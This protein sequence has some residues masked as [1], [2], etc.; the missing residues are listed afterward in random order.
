LPPIK[1]QRFGEMAHSMQIVYKNI[2]L[3][4]KAL[5]PDEEARA[6]AD[7]IFEHFFNLTPIQRVISETILDDEDKIPQIEA[8]IN[9]LLSQVPLQYVLGSAFF[10]DMELNVNSSVLIPRPETEELVSLILKHF[11]DR[12]A[13]TQLR[14]LDIG[15]GSGCIAIA[16]KRYLS[17]S[18]V[19]AI[20]ISKDAIEVAVSNA[21]KYH[22]DVNFIHADILDQTQWVELPQYELIVSNPPYVT[23]ADKLLMQPNVVNYEPHTALFVPEDDPLLFYRVITAFA[24]TKLSFEGSLWFEI[25]EMFGN[26]LRDMALNQGFK[27]VNI[28]FDFQG[29]S[30]FLQCSK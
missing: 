30:R 5:Y 16:L 9:K 15:T 19:S 2:V 20:D 3:K 8:A 17:H 28:I 23:Q 6:M 22:A 25:N 11:S 4:L 10:M 7:R 13:D 29:K 12:K 18:Q 27:E 24:K 21:S 14:V 26:E 1:Y